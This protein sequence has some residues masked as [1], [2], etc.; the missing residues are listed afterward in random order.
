MSGLMSSAS[1]ASPSSVASCDTPVIAAVTADV[2]RTRRPDVYTRPGAQAAVAAEPRARLIANGANLGFAAAVNVGIRA[3]TARYVFLLNPDAEITGGTLADLVKV[4]DDR[5]KAGA[6]GVLTK[7]PD[8]TVYPS[9]RKVPSLV[10][11]VGHAFLD[12]F[13]PNNRF[14]RAYRL[15]DWDR[16][17]ERAVDWVSGSSMLLRRSALDDVGLLDEGYWMY[18]EDLDVCTRLR[19]NGWQVLFAPVLEAT[20]R[21]GSVTAGKKRYTLLHSKS[22]YRYFVKF[23]SPGWKAAL[24]PFAWIALRL[25]AAIVSWR[26][27]NAWR[28]REGGYTDGA[29]GG[30]GDRCGSGSGTLVGLERVAQ[31]PPPGDPLGRDQDGH[32]RPARRRSCARSW[33][34]R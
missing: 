3:S 6:I 17:S 32:A 21:V 22:V 25:R 20:H 10:E 9:A 24:R 12:P 29:A 26:R 11:A 34:S 13:A 19:R 2:V 33:G 30:L 31:N 5:P 14:T 7:S 23:R 4:A 15:D 18:V 28:V 27:R 16:Q 1:S 8:G